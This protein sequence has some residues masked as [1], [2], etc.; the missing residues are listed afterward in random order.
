MFYFNFRIDPNFPLTAGAH[1]SSPGTFN[2]HHMKELP[3]TWKARLT[4]LRNAGLSH[5]GVMLVQSFMLAHDPGG[6][7]K[8][9]VLLERIR[10][11]PALQKDA[12]M[13]VFDEFF[14]ANDV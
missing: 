9:A 4:E 14:K 8:R 2:L 13:R 3:H 11:A 10:L 12:A 1:Y 5:A 7:N 6:K